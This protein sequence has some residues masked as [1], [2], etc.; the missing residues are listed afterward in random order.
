LTWTVRHILTAINGAFLHPQAH[1]VHVCH[2]CYLQCIY[3]ITMQIYM[4]KILTC[5]S[6]IFARHLLFSGIKI[7]K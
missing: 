7:I 1:S 4:S 5:E 2:S 6:L 3:V